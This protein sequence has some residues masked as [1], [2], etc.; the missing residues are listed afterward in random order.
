MHLCIFVYLLIFFFSSFYP[1]PLLHFSF[2][3]TSSSISLPPLL[4]ISLLLSLLLSLICFPL[5]FS[6]SHSLPFSLPPH[7]IYSLSPSFSFP[8]HPHHLLPP[9]LFLLSFSTFLSPFSLP[10]PTLSSPSS[11]PCLP[12]NLLLFFFQSLLPSSTLS[13]PCL[14]P[15]LFLFLLYSL[16]H[17][18]SLAHTYS[19]LNY[20]N[21]L[22]LLLFSFQGTH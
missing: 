22:T 4:P 10:S 8:S 17:P 6:S 5:F 3:S 7:L 1:S 21:G 14:P 13:F 11:S 20:E 19:V 18:F 9:L 15:P 2:L 16:S 12:P